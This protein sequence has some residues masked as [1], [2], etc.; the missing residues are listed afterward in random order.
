MKPEDSEGSSTV[1]VVLEMS[2]NDVDGFPFSFDFC[3][4]LNGPLKTASEDRLEDVERLNHCILSSTK[5]TITERVKQLKSTV[6]TNPFIRS[7][8]P[9]KTLL[10][11]KSVDFYSFVFDKSVNIE[12]T[13]ELVKKIVK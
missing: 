12:F 7:G 6:T 10:L 13:V 2:D 1:R 4:Y 8:I 3:F 9:S 11:S 5:A